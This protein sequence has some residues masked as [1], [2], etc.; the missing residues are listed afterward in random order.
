MSDCINRFIE[1]SINNN[2]IDQF[3]FGK[4]FFQFFSIMRSAYYVETIFF[5]VY[6]YFIKDRINFVVSPYNIIYIRVHKIIC[7]LMWRNL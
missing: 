3:G 6:D 4:P 7:H 1:I 2:S 5:K